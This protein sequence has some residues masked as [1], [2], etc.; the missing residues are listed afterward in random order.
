M[1]KLLSLVLCLSVCL[2]V[3]AGVAAANEYVNEASG[4]LECHTVAT[5]GTGSE[6]EQ[7]FDHEGLDCSV[8]H[9]GTP[10]TGNV[11]AETCTVCH[12]ELCES[13]VTH[14]E[15]GTTDC[16]TCHSNCATTDDD[17]D[18]A[19]DDDDDDDTSPCPSNAIYGAGSA[20]SEALRAYRDDVLSQTAAGQAVIDLYYQVSPMI[21]AAMEQSPAVEKMVKSSIDA[22]LPLIK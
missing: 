15:R 14:D 9:D 6:G 16:L 7:H 5:P 1:K 3:F 11:K 20:E 8:C 18:D 4:C 21:V 2:F 22:I 13:V 12:F 17:D 10:A 19:A